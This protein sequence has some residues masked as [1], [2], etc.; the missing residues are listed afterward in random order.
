MTYYDLLGDPR[1]FNRFLHWFNTKYPDIKEPHYRNLI[2]RLLQVRTIQEYGN[3]LSDRA[4]IID[5]YESLRIEFGMGKRSA[6]LV[7]YNIFVDSIQKH[8]VQLS[9]LHHYDITQ[10]VN[11]SELASVKAILKEL[12]YELE[13]V[14][15]KESNTPK[16][17][18]VT[19][20]L[21]FLLP[22]LV[23]P[24]DRESVQ[25]FLYLKDKTPSSVDKQFD[26]FM[27]VFDQYIAL[28]QKLN[29]R[30]NNGDGNWWNMSVPKRIDNA[31]AG[32]WMIFNT[33]NIQG[34]ICN[35][36]D[37]LLVQLKMP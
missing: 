15:E 5:A 21:H 26:L 23:M 13:V 35:N 9:K 34:L 10:M 30:S 18:A 36:I 31:I 7:E 14:P 4:Y 16:L 28:S 1:Y 25:K 20:T 24:V 8:K 22:S 6:K 19:K 33:E 11:S 37:Q 32:F 12:F 27:D 2:Q 29:L 17:V 3:L